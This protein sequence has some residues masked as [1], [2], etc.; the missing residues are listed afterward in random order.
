MY[1]TSILNHLAELQ[2]LYSGLI[3]SDI[4]DCT[5]NLIKGRTKDNQSMLTGQPRLY[6]PQFRPP[7]LTL[8]GSRFVF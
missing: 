3:W 7:S 6:C 4:L 5:F 2:F 1:I 8:H